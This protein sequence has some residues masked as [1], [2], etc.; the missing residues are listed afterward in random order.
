MPNI[1]LGTSRAR[2]ND[3]KS[4]RATILEN[5]EKELNAGNTTEYKSLLTKAQA[6]NDQIEDLN[7]L[8]K[9]YDRYEIARAPKFGSD[10]TDM[11]A[12][13]EM[14]LAGERVGFAA[15]LVKQALVSNTAAA[16]SG[17]IVSPTGGSAQINDGFNAQVSGVIDQV[18]VEVFDGL[19]AWEESYLAS[20]QTATNGKP[21]AVGGTTRADSAPVWKKAK[22]LRLLFLL[23]QCLLLPNLSFGEN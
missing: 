9:E 5:A 21:S 6:M 2:L 1:T 12:M 8:V 23:Q 13:G 4:Q 11:K 15:D 22:L 14:L 7:S 18:R 3:L 16:F 20:M 19:G 17:N 10:P